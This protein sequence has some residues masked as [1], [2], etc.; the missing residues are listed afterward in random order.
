V[1]VTPSSSPETTDLLGARDDTSTTARSSGE[2]VLPAVSLA[3]LLG[4][5][6]LVALGSTQGLD[7]H[8]R[9]LFR[10]DDQWGDLQIGVDPFIEVFSPV[11]CVGLLAVATASTAVWRRSW[12]PVVCVAPAVVAAC[13]LTLALKLLVGRPDTHGVV[14]TLGGSYPSGHVVAVL[15]AAGCLALLGRSTP[16][17]LTWLLV[18]LAGAVMSWALLVQT[19][20]WFTDVF[21]GGLVALLV[22]SL[23]VHLPFNVCAPTGQ[24]TS[25]RAGVRHRHELFGRAR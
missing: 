20:H 21:G 10:P 25:R 13:L 18:A 11:V 1:R 6:V 17:G 2:L 16:T 7:Q 5:T 4:L 9:T 15:V 23:T 24:R 14:A 8:V 12:R 3:A 22:L 19:A